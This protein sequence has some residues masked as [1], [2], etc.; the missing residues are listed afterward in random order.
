[1]KF[2]ICSV[3][4]GCEGGD[5]GHTHGGILP[6]QLA[7]REELAA[8]TP[9]DREAFLAAERVEEDRLNAYWAAQL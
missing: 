7:R 1:M 8:M 6:H 3:V 4:E 5:C 9:A 2:R